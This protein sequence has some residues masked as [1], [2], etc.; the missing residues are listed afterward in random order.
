MQTFLPFPNF[1]DSARVLDRQRLGKQRVEAW[2][3]I[4]TLAPPS[5]VRRGWVNHPAVCMWRGHELALCVYGVAICLAWRERGYRDTMLERFTTVLRSAS[6]E[7]PTAPAWLGDP[8]FHAS[9]RAAL[10]AK[11]VEWYGRFRWAE[12]PEI[13]Y[14]WPMP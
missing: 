4:T 13:A 1:H 14:V 3:I 2:Q 5:D 8:A 7:V 6:D 10:L 12:T 11:N 9:H